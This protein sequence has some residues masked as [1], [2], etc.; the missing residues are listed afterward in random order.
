[1]GCQPILP[2]EF[3]IS[4]EPPLEEFLERIHSDALLSPRAISHKNTPLPTSLPPDLAAADFVFVRRDSTA[5]PLTPPYTGPFRVLRRSLHD[6]QLQIGDRSEVVSTHRLKICISPPDVTAAVPPRRGRPPLVPP[7]ATT[8]N[9][10]PG[11]KTTLKIRAEQ[12]AGSSLKK[13]P[14]GVNPIGKK[15]PVSDL[16]EPTTTHQTGFPPHRRRAAPPAFRTTPVPTAQRNLREKLSTRQVQVSL[17]VPVPYRS[18][19]CVKKIR[20]HRGPPLRTAVLPSVPWESG[21]VSLSG[22]GFPV[23]PQSFRHRFLTL[24]HPKLNRTR[25]R[26]QF[27]DPAA[28]A[29]A[30]T[31]RSGWA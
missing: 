20:N 25:I 26:I 13:C 11:E 23:A 3:L 9:Q 8:P 18:R 15:S 2:G 29:A 5:P 14:K 7:G 1:M 24:P 6:F 12:T 22:L 31:N 10:K 17:P 30:V 4:G 19:F 28:R 21:W 16:K 27:P